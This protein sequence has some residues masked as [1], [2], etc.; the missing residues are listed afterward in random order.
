MPT[1]VAKRK[2]KAP[3]SSNGSASIADRMAAGRA[4]RQKVPRSSQAGWQPAA[5]RPD[6]IAE[7][8][9]SNLGRVPDLIPIRY[10]RMLVSPFAFLRGAAAIMA[11]D[12]SSTPVTGLKVQVCG[13][14]HL[15]NFGAFATPE[16]N[17]IFDI[18]DFD[19]TLPAPWEWDVKRL[20]ASVVVAGRH[21]ELGKKACKKAAL[22]AVESYRSRMAAYATMTRIDVWYSRLDVSAFSGLIRSSKSVAFKATP[23]QIVHSHPGAHELPKLTDVVKGRLRII[24]RPPLIFHPKQHN[25]ALIEHTRQSFERYRQTLRDDVRALFDHYRFVDSAIKVV[26][27]GSVGTRCGIALFMAGDDDPLFLQ[28]KEAMPS[29]LERYAGKSRY[30]NHGQRVV[31][32]QRLMQAASDMFLGWIRREDG[33]DFYIRQLRDMKASADIENMK[34][35]DLEEYAGFCGWA[36]ARAHARAGDPAFIAGYIGQRDPF[37]RAIVE[38][39]CAYADQNES[40]YDEFSAAVKAGRIRA[41]ALR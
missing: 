26:G 24:G 15:A 38:F 25:D 27:V 1:A 3:F 28:I 30:E 39:A 41:E 10:G 37:D 23:S 19:E 35:P 31:A 13:D 5:N 29:V 33:R 20:C 14:A 11:S 22:A 9:E 16:R 18:N 12:L 32:G 6:P 17:F 8:E 2:T 36:L 40:D 7:L 34:A 4:R 21:I